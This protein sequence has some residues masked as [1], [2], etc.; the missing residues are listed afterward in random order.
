MKKFTLLFSFLLLAG[1]IWAQVLTPV[2][3]S[4]KVNFVIKNFGINT[5]GNFQGLAG[6]IKYDPLNPLNSSFDVSVKAETVDT[7]IDA[8]DNHLRKSEFF[9][10][11]NFPLIQFKSTKVSLTN[12]SEHLYMFATITIKG[13]QKNVKFPFTV[14]EI[15]GGYLFEG[16]FELNRLDFNVGGKSISLSNDVNVNLSVFAR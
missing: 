8:R 7:D 12:S 5:S 9:D 2:D 14:K 16:S 1:G 13:V 4:S 6:M 11:K 10:V 15:N 3:E